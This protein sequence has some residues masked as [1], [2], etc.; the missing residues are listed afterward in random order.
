MTTTKS[1]GLSAFVKN[2]LCEKRR[3]FNGMCFKYQHVKSP[4]Q[5]KNNPYL[6]LLNNFKVPLKFNNLQC[7]VAERIISSKASTKSRCAAWS[8]QLS[9]ESNKD[10]KRDRLADTD[11]H[12]EEDR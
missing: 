12:K 6:E 2:C 7:R 4:I 1:F 5:L 11:A 10:R 9:V 3:I 8:K